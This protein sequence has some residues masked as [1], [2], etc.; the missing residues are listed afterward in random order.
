MLVTPNIRNALFARRRELDYY[1][2]P[3]SAESI[4]LRELGVDWIFGVISRDAT[5]ATLDWLE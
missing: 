3:H 4:D 2:N 1:E 5:G